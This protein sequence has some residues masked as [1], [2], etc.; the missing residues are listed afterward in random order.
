[1]RRLVVVMAAVLLASLTQA[2]Y[3]QTPPAGDGMMDKTDGQMGEEK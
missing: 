3:A 2:A 1:M